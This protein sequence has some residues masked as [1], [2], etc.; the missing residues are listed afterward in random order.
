MPTRVVS[1]PLLMPPWMFERDEVG[2]SLFSTLEP[3]QGFC[4][5]AKWL[6]NPF[7]GYGAA[8]QEALRIRPR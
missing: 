1:L 5:P 6:D 2:N 8:L 3:R 4:Q 7:D